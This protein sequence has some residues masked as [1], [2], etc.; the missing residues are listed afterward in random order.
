MTA[1]RARMEAE[2]PEHTTARRPGRPRSA[3]AD[4]AILAAAL[5][6]FAEVGPDAMSIEGVAERAGV[7]K[8]TIYRRWSSKEE[9]VSAAVGTLSEDLSAPDAGTVR[10]DLVGL[11]R[12]MIRTLASEPTGRVLPRIA[13]EMASGSSIGR[14]YA[15]TVLGPR[16]ELVGAVLRRGLERGELRADLDVELAIDELIGPLIVRRLLGGPGS[17]TTGSLPEH[18][19]DAVLRGLAR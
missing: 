18:L 6:L 17:A 7:G 3:R 10:D 11:A 4:R 12:Q 8:T 2:M 16:R 14:T 9:L 19:V 5:E 13:S 1:S 15:R